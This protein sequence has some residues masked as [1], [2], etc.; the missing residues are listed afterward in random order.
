MSKKVL[1]LGGNRFFGKHLVVELLKNNYEVTLLNRGQIDDQLGSQ[2]QRL[3]A[4]RKDINSLSHVLKNK[5]WDMV[6]D[7]ICFE[8]QDAKNLCEL[9]LGQTAKILFTSSQSVYDYGRLIPEEIFNPFTYQYTKAARQAEA[10]AE[11]KRQCETVFAQYKQLHPVML[12]MPLVLGEDDYTRRLFWHMDKCINGLP[13]YFPNDQAHL[14]FIRSD[15]AGKMISDISQTDFIG[16]INCA[17]PGIIKISQLMALIENI[18]G[19]QMIRALQADTDNHS[20]YGV[21]EDWTMNLNKLSLL[22]I[23]APQLDTWLEPLIRNMYLH[24]K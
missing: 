14:G 9:M 15:F 1:V 16:P 18:T 5:T 2:V 13:V 24:N 4:D 3:K 22:N 8:E 12:R 7:Q 21:T 6:F 20:P 19:R 11:A 10:Y 17:C 23:I